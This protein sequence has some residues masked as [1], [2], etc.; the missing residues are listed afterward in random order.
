MN[1]LLAP[2]FNL[3]PAMW[4]KRWWGLAIAWCFALLGAFGVLHYKE[5]YLASATVYVDTQTTLRPLLEGLA[6]Q[7]DISQQ[8]A[9]LAHTM[10]SRENLN[11]IIDRNHLLPPGASDLKRELLIQRLGK[12]IGFKVNGRDN[13]YQVSFV[14]TDPAKTLGVVRT[15][16]DLFVD[17]GLHSN[18]QDS[19]QA[20][21]FIDSQI[22]LYDA[23]LRDA[24]NQLRQFKTAHPGYSAQGGMDYAARQG[25]LQD[26]LV[27][28]QGQLAAATSARDA[29]QAQLADVRPTLAPQLVPGAGIMAAPQADSL[30]QQI[31]LQRSRLDQLLQRYTDAYPDVIATRSLLAR[32][33]AQKRRE[34]ASA[35]AA[36]S[37]AAPLYSQATNP[38][39][40]QLRISLAQASANVASLQTQLSDVRARLQAINAHERQMPGL[41]EQYA[42]LTRDYKV[43]SDNYQKLVQRREAATLSRNQDQSRSHD[44]FHVVDPPRL[45]PTALFPHRTMLIALVLVLAVGFGVGGAYLLVALFPTYR[46]TRQLR[47]GTERAVLGSISL[48]L[49]PQAQARERH[50]FLLF[51]AGSA[52]LVVAFASWTLASMLHLIH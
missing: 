43:L 10:L 39:Y 27:S 31:A 7:P 48:V 34:E 25:Q 13:I 46:T 19:A 2:L 32:L 9:L 49:T 22:A 16:L 41:D 45:A 3:L 23:K 12:T 4:E 36:P 52:I 29:L 11:K 42:Q 28:L 33:E 40:Q 1:D 30:D 35:A 26:Q 18:A 50:Q 6:V 14:G 24:E 51:I 17:T 8:V 21:H 20:L 44:Y 5:R 37:H 38:V 47:E 15:L